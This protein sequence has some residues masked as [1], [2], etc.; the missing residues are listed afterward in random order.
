MVSW[1]NLSWALR[2]TTHLLICST[3]TLTLIRCHIIT[4]GWEGNA[5]KII[6]ESMTALRILLWRKRP[7]FYDTFNLLIYLFIYLWWKRRNLNMWRNYEI[8]CLLR[9]DNELVR[10]W[11]G[12]FRGCLIFDICVSNVSFD[13]F[14]VD[15]HGQIGVIQH[16]ILSI[17]LHF[18]LPRYNLYFVLMYVLM[19]CSCSFSCECAYLIC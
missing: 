8:Y 4:T 15:L 1:L 5:Q 6:M 3:A 10:S 17:M 18:F 7:D 16:E 12:L 14:D 9:N 19:S 11:P 13:S 2:S